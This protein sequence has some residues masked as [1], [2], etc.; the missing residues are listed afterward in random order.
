MEADLSPGP[1]SIRYELRIPFYGNENQFAPRTG[2]SIKINRDPLD[3]LDIDYWKDRWHNF[4]NGNG[5]FVV[6]GKLEFVVK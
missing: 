4:I 6:R 5:M 1:H 2:K 3:R